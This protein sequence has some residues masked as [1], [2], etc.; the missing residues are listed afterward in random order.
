MRIVGLSV[1][2]SAFNSETRRRGLPK[3][4]L[5]GATDTTSRRDDFSPISVFTPRYAP[6]SVSLSVP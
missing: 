3:T 6:S 5:D 2:S 4:D 1:K